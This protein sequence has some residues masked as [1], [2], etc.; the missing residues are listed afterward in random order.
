MNNL[1]SSNWN[2]EFYARKVTSWVN[3][4]TSDRRIF[5]YLSSATIM[6]YYQSVPEFQSKK[7]RMMVMKVQ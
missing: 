3:N 2:T 1:K 4:L 5:Y 7:F 6:I